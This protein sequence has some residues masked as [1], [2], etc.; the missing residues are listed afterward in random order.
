MYCLLIWFNVFCSG[1]FFQ[2]AIWPEKLFSCISQKVNNMNLFV[3]HQIIWKTSIITYISIFE[4]KCLTNKC[5]CQWKS[6]FKQ[7]DIEHVM[8]VII[9]SLLLDMLKKKNWLITSTIPMLPMWIIIN[10]EE[11]HWIRRIP[12]YLAMK[13]M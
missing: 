8:V 5:E 2:L 6:L 10:N 12:F 13:L 1:F 11:S 3:C 9:L 7:N 4:Q